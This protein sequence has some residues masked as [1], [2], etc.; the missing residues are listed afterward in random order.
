MSISSFSPELTFAQWVPILLEW[1]MHKLSRFFDVSSTHLI[2]AL[3]SS[4]SSAWCDAHVSFIQTAV[5]YRSYPISTRVS[6]SNNKVSSASSVNSLDQ[7][8]VINEAAL[9]IPKSSKINAR[10]KNMRPNMIYITDGLIKFDATSTT[11]T[12]LGTM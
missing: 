3:L 11:S 9:C 2:C 5:A 8:Q 6:S 1:A 4:S 10:L 12:F 7:L